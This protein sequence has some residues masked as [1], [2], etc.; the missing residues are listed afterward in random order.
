MLCR[1]PSLGSELWAGIASGGMVPV[2]PDQPLLK[3]PTPDKTGREPQDCRDFSEGMTMAKQAGRDQR[4]PMER[5]VRLASVL[6][7][8][9][10]EGVSADKLLRAGEYDGDNAHDLLSRDLRHLR[11][12]GWQIDNM[13]AEGESGRYRM[14]TVDNRLRVRLT[15][16][17][18][19]ALQ[20]A[21]ILADRADLVERLGLSASEQPAEVDAALSPRAHDERLSAALRAVRHR[22]VLRFRYGGKDRVVHPESV[23]AQN[24]QWYLRGVE[25]DNDVLKAFVVAR[26]SGVTSDQPG[27]SRVVAGE[28]ALE[29]HPMRFQMD[30]PIEVTLSTT[31]AHQPDV[32]RWLGAPMRAEPS[33]E[34]VEMTYEVTNRAAMRCRLY[35]LGPRVTLIGP[36]EFRQELLSELAAAGGER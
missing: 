20:R 18:Q 13:H 10:T 11:G 6:K 12:Q 27:T 23:R 34:Q 24:E 17:Q 35:E 2:H 36:D 26:M 30:P 33:G 8:A 3:S 5:L 25:D 7:A 31:T 14:V 21:V 28:P 16:Q 22:A 1:T 32:E 4:A 19:T 9:G 15:P 29:L